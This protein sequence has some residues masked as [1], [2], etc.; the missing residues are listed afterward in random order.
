MFC[1]KPGHVR[2]RVGRRLRSKRLAGLLCGFL[3]TSRSFCWV[4]ILF[5]LFITKRE[6]QRSSRWRVFRPKGF[7]HRCCCRSI[8]RGAFGA[9]R[10]GHSAGRPA[11]VLRPRQ[12]RPPAGEPRPC[13]YTYFK[14]CAVKQPNAGHHKE[15][16]VQ[17]H[18]LCATL[19]FGGQAALSDFL[20]AS[21]PALRRVSAADA[22]DC[23]SSAVCLSGCLSVCCCLSVAACLVLPVYF[24]LFITIGL[25]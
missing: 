20:R 5:R 15:H 1:F 24:C 22:A 6:A 21:L 17:L 10:G 3:S 23:R 9:F 7:S 25:G 2:V 13:C 16:R 11:A 14:L 18:T 12:G 8:F 4:R 19:S